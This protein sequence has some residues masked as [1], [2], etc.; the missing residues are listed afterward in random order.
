MIDRVLGFVPALWARIKRGMAAVG[1]VL[2]AGAVATA[3]AL[4]LG[5]AGPMAVIAIFCLF[6]GVGVI[7]EALDRR[8]WR[9]EA[10]IRRDSPE[11][12]LDP[13]RDCRVHRWIGQR[14]E[15]ALPEFVERG[16]WDLLCSGLTEKRFVFLVG[17]GTCGKSR[18]AFE[19][20]AKLS[21]V[22]LVAHDPPSLG[23]DPLRALMEDK[24]G[25]PAMED[26][27]ILLI[28]DVARRLRAGSLTRRL[29]REWL[30]QNP[31]VSLIAVLSQRDEKEIAEVGESLNGDLMDLMAESEVVEVHP[32]L[33]R[34]DRDKAKRI[35]PHLDDRDLENL[36]QY[37]ASG[38]PLLEAVEQARRNE[39]TLGLAIIKVVCDW[40]RTGASL[41]VSLDFLKEHA[42]RFANKRDADE[43]DRELAWALSPVTGDAALIYERVSPGGRGF[44]PDSTVIELFTHPVSGEAVNPLIWIN[45]LTALSRLSHS[46]KY[47]RDFIAHELVSFG[48]AAFHA[49]EESMGRKAFDIASDLD[50]Q[51]R[52]LIAEFVVTDTESTLVKSRRGD[53]LVQRLQPVEQLTEGRRRQR[54]GR[55]RSFAG[56]SP[57]TFAWIYRRQWLRSL[58]R[59]L[60]LASADLASVAL[61]LFAGLEVRGRLS[62]S[63]GAVQT[64]QASSYAGIGLAAAATLFVFGWADLYKKDAMRARI[65]AIASVASVLAVF[66]WI[67]ALADGTNV[68]PAAGAAFCGGLVCLG[69]DALLRG[70][71]DSI[72]RR[73][74]IRNSFEARTLLVGSPS[75]VA[76]LEKALKDF[77]RP[78]NVVG[79]LQDGQDSPDDPVAPGLPRLGAIDDLGDVA[80]RY[81]IGRVILADPGIQADRRQRIAD[82]CH[83]RHLIIEARASFSDI[84]NG[85]ARFVLGQPAVL[86]PLWPLWPRNTWMIAKR[87]GD[88]VLSVVA[89]LFFSIPML[90][91]AICIRVQGGPVIVRALRLGLGGEPFY[92]LRF[93][94]SPG[95]VGGIDILD[96]EPDGLNARIWMGTLLRRSG[97]DELPQLFNVL[98]GHM[99]L[100][101]PRPLELRH[102]PFLDERQLQRYLVRPGATGP[103]QVCRRTTLTYEELTSLDLAYIR[104]WSIFTDFEILARTFLLMF[105]RR[106]VPSIA[107]SDNVHPES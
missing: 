1:A 73:W 75:A 31:R 43:F 66:G 89:L 53:G 16:E 26:H 76:D 90:F 22:T 48:K 67:V 72:S 28:N 93:R 94:T 39:N 4:M 63:V 29:V 57:R 95:D 87:L 60:F 52:Q 9:I 69:A 41:P 17:K 30:D 18:L 23:E 65:E 19:A 8:R 88:I 45:A 40:H 34:R 79:Y 84:R 36:P 11:K 44:V 92:M 82:R 81:A 10:F 74:V 83:E 50:P 20:C 15:G 51:V 35:F 49:G 61:G 5:V 37:F 100:V 71:Y 13:I 64:I 77:S 107:G 56:G 105:T 38:P 21:H 3:L 85:L 80:Q 2:A 106:T 7:G 25:F 27:Q 103:W 98:R 24:R 62:S 99:S 12:N 104:H 54:G 102:H 46:G 55:L 33:N 14:G 86:I 91:I 78:M 97:F 70:I 47:S 59:L 96:P 42:Q 68:L 58:T 32:S 6:F 101:G